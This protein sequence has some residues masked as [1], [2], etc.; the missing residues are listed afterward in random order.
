MSDGTGAAEGSVELEHEDGV[1]VLRLR[2]SAL[3][4]LT[5]SLRRDIR[6]ALERAAADLAIRAIVITGGANFCAGADLKEFGARSDPAVAEAHCRNGHAMTL[7][8]ASCDKPL[9]AALEGACLGGGF[10]I[11]LCCDAR[12]A[13][14]NA[15]LGLPEIGRGIFP[16]TGGVP[17]L[18]RLVGPSRTK[19]LVLSGRIFETSSP[20]ADGIVDQRVEPGTAFR[21]ARDW[22]R[23]W[24]AQPAGSVQAIKRLADG[25]FRHRLRDRLEAERAEYIAAFARADA[26]EGWRAFLEKRAPAWT[27]A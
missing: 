16:G 26:R 8:L 13:A 20:A 6:T 4:L 11:A 22:A 1:A 21:I 17:L 9:V 5:Q 12:I 7:A 19:D 25:E 14:S 23:G 24:A 15:R 18:E 10:E 2:A 27:H 3:N